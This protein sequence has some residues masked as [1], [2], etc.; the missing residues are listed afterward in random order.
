[1]AEDTKKSKAEIK[2]ATEKPIFSWQSP[3][4]VRYKKDKKWFIYMILV[5]IALAIIFS[6]LHQ[7]SGV[8]LVVV[9]ALV[10]ITLSGAHPK[11]VSCAVYSAGIVVDGKVYDFS[12]FKSFWMTYGDL[13]KIKMQ[14]T[15]RIAGQIT[16]PLGQEDPEQIRLFFEKH[17]PQEEDKGDDLNDTVNRLL[18]F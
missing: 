9:A 5:V 16:I 15:G 4:F 10:F 7:W 13:P 17:L 2:I 12:Q 14:L 6:L 11:N 3:E 18:R 1:M 8:A